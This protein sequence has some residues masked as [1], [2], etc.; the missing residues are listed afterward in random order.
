[1]QNVPDPRV[2]AMPPVTL[3]IAESVA[4][5]ILTTYGDS[6]HYDEFAYAEA[7]GALT[8]ALQAL[9]DALANERGVSRG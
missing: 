2:G 7:Y 3:D 1:M 8:V 5:Q 6:T 9:L 4:R